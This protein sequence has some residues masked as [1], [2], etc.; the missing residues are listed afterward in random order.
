MNP[1]RIKVLLIEDN[2]GDAGLIQ[3]SLAKAA[4]QLFDLEVVDTLATGLQ[5]LSAGGVDAM[6]LDLALP[7][8]FGFETFNTAK[9]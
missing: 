7:D 5:H 9:P 8:S 1:Q 4:H 6:L 2:P 3:E